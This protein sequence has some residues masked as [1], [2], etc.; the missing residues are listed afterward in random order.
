MMNNKDD[1]TANSDRLEDS[2]DRKAVEHVPS[3]VLLLLAKLLLY[4]QAS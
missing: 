1:R 2:A 3:A 4:L